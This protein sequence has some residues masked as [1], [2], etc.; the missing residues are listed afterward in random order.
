M[1]KLFRN[2]RKN[3]LNQ[4]K[5][6]NYLKYA[7]GEIVLVVIGILIALSINNWNQNRKNKI[8]E[9]WIL[10]DIHQEF[11][12]NKRQLDTVVFY[13]RRSF[14]NCKKLIAL[15]PIDIKKDNL[16]SIALFTNFSLFTY[17]FNPSQGSLNSLI[18]TASFNIIQN[19]TLR[20]I[21]ISWQDLVTDLQEDEIATRN[22]VTRL[23]DPYFSKNF[24]YYFNL[25]DKRNRLEFFETLEFEYV[26][27]LR[28]E[29][30]NNIFK[31]GAEL[32]NVTKNLNKIIELTKPKNDD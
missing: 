17:T 13:N 19:K 24:N 9:K 4:G 5:T 20:K 29:N 18:N 22:T 6:T 31:E 14:R 32:E 8:L 27:N 10:A 3:L 15:F 16:D 2:I 25:N 26:M 30:L 1:I 28:F 12:Q 11:I 7:I 23:I 21:L